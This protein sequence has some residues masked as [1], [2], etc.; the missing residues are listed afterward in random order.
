MRFRPDIASL[1]EL[2][3]PISPRLLLLKAR[4][5]LSQEYTF[6]IARYVHKVVEEGY[7]NRLALGFPK[8]L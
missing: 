3:K 1:K 6:N 8:Y 7:T 2:T 5:E 4:N